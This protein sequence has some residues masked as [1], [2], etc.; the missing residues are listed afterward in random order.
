[1]KGNENEKNL[2]RDSHAG[3]L[4]LAACDG[5]A[6]PDQIGAYGNRAATQ[7]P[8]LRT[9]GQPTQATPPTPSPRCPTAAR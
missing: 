5:G 2:A 4:V 3:C 9:R 6:E 8:R 1:M 7:P